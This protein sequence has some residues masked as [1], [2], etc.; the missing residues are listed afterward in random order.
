MKIKV[1]SIGKVK[2][3]SVEIKGLTFLA[4]SNASGKSIIGECLYASLDSLKDLKEKVFI[5][6]KKWLL[7]FLMELRGSLDWFTNYRLEWNLM[8]QSFKI[9][10]AKHQ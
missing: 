1:I 2:S 9:F 4:G 5:S 10:L 6:K 3:A 7:S 8:V